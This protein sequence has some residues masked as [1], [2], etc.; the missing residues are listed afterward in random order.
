[1]ADVTVKRL[2]EFEAI[3]GGAFRREQFDLLG[4]GEWC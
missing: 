1:M 4:G 3:F 2:D